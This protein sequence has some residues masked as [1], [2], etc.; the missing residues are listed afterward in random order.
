[1]SW[2]AIMNESGDKVNIDIGPDQTRPEFIQTKTF[3]FNRGSLL[4]RDQTFTSCC[5]G[6][7]NFRCEVSRMDAQYFLDII[8]PSTVYIP[9][10]YC[11]F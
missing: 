9:H 6:S 7:L 8:C 10:P 4:D 11:L 1:M 3:A 5:L 2:H